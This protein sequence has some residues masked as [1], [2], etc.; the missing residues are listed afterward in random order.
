MN[1]NLLNNA[2]NY[3]NISYL[4]IIDNAYRL[5]K[6]TLTNTILMIIRFTLITCLIKAIFICASVERIYTYDIIIKKINHIYI[7]NI[8]CL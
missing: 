4:I 6:T 5:S 8:C 1:Y 2:V 7:L 3:V